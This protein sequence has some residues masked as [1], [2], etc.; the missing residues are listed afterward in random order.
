MIDPL[1][2]EIKDLG[3]EGEVLQHVADLIARTLDEAL[4]ELNKLAEQ[5]SPEV[6]QAMDAAEVGVD[7]EFYG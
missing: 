1:P 4:Q 5:M 7:I 2:I 3:E 6:Q